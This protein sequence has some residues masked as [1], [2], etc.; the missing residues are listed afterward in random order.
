M[1]YEAWRITFQSS[2]QAARSAFND[3][4][5]ARAEIARLK[6]YEPG[7]KAKPMPK[8]VQI[9]PTDFKVWGIIDTE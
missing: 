9:A 4:S 7:N 8:P 3:L 1:N 6:L 2:E 5:A